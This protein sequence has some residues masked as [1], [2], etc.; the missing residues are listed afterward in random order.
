MVHFKDLAETRLDEAIERVV[1][2][3]DYIFDTEDP[4]YKAYAKASSMRVWR[5]NTREEIRKGLKKTLTEEFKRKYKE[6]N[7]SARPLEELSE[8]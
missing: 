2:N 8:A 6:E 3:N 7:P 4:I 5:R 1:A